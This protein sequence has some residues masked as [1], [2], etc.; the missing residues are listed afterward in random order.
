MSAAIGFDNGK[1]LEEQSAEILRRCDLSGNK[2]YLEFGGKLMYDYH[3]TRVLPGYDP[4][5][6]LRLLQ[7]LKEKAEIIIC[8]YAGDIERKKMRADFGISY[9]SDAMKLIDDLR[10]WDLSVCGVVITR[11]EGQPAAAQFKTKLERRGVK[12]YCH[13]T[14]PGYPNN[15]DFIVSDRGYGGNEYVPTSRPIVVVTGPGPGSGKLAT[16]LTMLYHDRRAG[17]PAGYAKFETFPVW[18]MPLKH[19]VN[20]AYEAA[21]AELHDINMIDP[22]H[23]EAHGAVAVNYNRDVESFPIL[24]A[25][26]DRIDTENK[27]PYQSPTDMGVNR[28]GFG[29]VDDAIVREASRQEIL[30]RYFRHLSDATVNGL[31]D[32]RAIDRIETLMQE[33]GLS[34]EDRPVVDP[35]RAAAQ[36]AARTHTHEKH[37]HCGAAIRLHDGRIVK[38]KNSNMLHAASST[39]LNALKTVADIDDETH[40]LAPEVVSSI[41]NMKHEILK[42]RYS[43]LNLDE[44]LIGLAISAAGSGTESARKALEA[45]PQLRECEM[46]LSHLLTPG[47]EA[48]LRRLGIRYTT[49]PIFST[50]ELFMDG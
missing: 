30:R 2:L 14:V 34:P 49:D 28:I 27:C 8:I 11:F 45:L 12:V 22:F 25:I 38:G 46:H 39:V 36:E 5:V 48:G 35:A 16:C 4:N 26:W 1:Y 6:K 41:V 17:R 24:K 44:T 3:A 7:R 10:S 32:T 40:L 43:S 18:N 42:S 33:L 50:S 21:T 23:L 19:P 13:S 15:V 31:T 37:I 29:I 47:D 9:E 20:I